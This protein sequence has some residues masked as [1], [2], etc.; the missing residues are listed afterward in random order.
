[1]KSESSAAMWLKF[2]TAAGIPND[3]AEHYAATFS[4]NQ[5]QFD[6]L[7]EINKEYLNDMGITLLGHVIAILR[8]A[9]TVYADEV[10]KS[11]LSISSK[12]QGINGSKEKSTSTSAMKSNKTLTISKISEEE[13][14]PTTS[15]KRKSSVVQLN[16]NEGSEP[17]SKVRK[18]L[19]DSSDDI[20][21]PI[22]SKPVVS[23]PTT[24]TTT[25]THTHTGDTTSDEI[26]KG[27]FR[28]LGSEVP[29][30]SA[31]TSSQITINSESVF[32]RLGGKTD[33]PQVAKVAA[34]ATAKRVLSNKE[35]I[36]AKPLVR[37][38]IIRNRLDKPSRIL[39]S[40]T[41]MDSILAER[42]ISSSVT[43]SLQ[44]KRDIKARLGFSSSKLLNTLGPGNVKKVSFG[45]VYQKLIPRVK[46]PAFR[47]GSFPLSGAQRI[48]IGAS[49]LNSP[50]FSGGVSA[51][52]FNSKKLSVGPSSGVF[53]R[54]GV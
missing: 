54:L 1:M 39:V 13:D 45:S 8:H 19:C 20:A 10:K 46:K 25:S 48:S 52:G 5:I 3:P 50:K 26:K 24:T 33:T 23:K 53:S 44:E 30:S 38:S 41:Y 32:S 4:K 22:V 35:D 42:S 27:V 29:Q 6:M 40:P 18:N 9:K 17:K 14:K 2:F 12:K 7:P 28:R 16:S 49:S 47:S 51:Y 15:T 21:M 37:K 11:E 31:E 34:L 36:S 43:N